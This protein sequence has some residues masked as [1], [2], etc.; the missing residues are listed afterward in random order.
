MRPL[1]GFNPKDISEFLYGYYVGRFKGMFHA[2][3]G[4]E[5]DDDPGGTLEDI[6]ELIESHALKIRDFA[7]RASEHRED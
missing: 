6:I 3:H 7:Q 1:R 4:G 5:Q 2:V